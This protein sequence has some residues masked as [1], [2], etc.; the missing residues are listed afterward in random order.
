MR[1][2]IVVFLALLV[3]APLLGADAHFRIHVGGLQRVS[4]F[5]GPVV[6]VTDKI[7]AAIGN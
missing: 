6:R 1:S 4:A 3:C 5:D 7:E 2:G